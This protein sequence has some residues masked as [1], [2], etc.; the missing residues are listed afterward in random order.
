[1]SIIPN[2]KTYTIISIIPNK[3]LI[4]D[5][6]KNTKNLIIREICNKT[7]LEKN[8]D[9]KGAQEPEP[10]ILE[11]HEK[12]E[13]IYKI[14]PDNLLDVILEMN[15]KGIE[16]KEYNG[17]ILSGGK[18]INE[19]EDLDDISLDNLEDVELN[20]VPKDLSNNNSI[21]DLEDFDDSESDD[22][23][24]DDVNFKNF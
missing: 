17:K 16:L 7:Y 8:E 23:D 21:F 10:S 2:K 3:K 1:M 19:F 11:D 20:Y 6:S 24:D 18:K 4:Y 14:K 15:K 22:D 5:L 12:N 13:I 9:E